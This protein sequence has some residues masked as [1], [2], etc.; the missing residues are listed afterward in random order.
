MLEPITA[1]SHNL[2]L[3]LQCFPWI[4]RTLPVRSQLRQILP[5]G[6]EKAQSRLRASS[7]IFKVGIVEKLGCVFP[8]VENILELYIVPFWGGSAS[9]A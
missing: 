4:N 6:S 9:F 1:L 5:P 7:V 3:H 8:E 2:F